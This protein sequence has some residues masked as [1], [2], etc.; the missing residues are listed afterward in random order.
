MEEVVGAADADWVHS[1]VEA[2]RRYLEGRRAKEY[3]GQAIEVY[4]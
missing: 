4:N 2:R 3:L 1:Y